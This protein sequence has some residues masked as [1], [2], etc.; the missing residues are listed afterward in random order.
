MKDLPPDCD[1][2]RASGEVNGV[3]IKK[4]KP[5]VWK[6][7]VVLDAWER[8]PAAINLFRGWKPLPPGETNIRLDFFL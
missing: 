2:R 3:R 1:R 5:L 7:P 8:L 4:N 6:E